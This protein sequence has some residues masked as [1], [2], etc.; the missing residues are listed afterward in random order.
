[1]EGFMKKKN[2]SDN[3]QIYGV[4]SLKMYFV[5]A[6]ILDDKHQIKE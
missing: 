4:F 1:M 6:P 5:T 3:I 2:L